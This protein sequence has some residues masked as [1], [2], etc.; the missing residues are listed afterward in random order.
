MDVVDHLILLRCG[1]ATFK[2]HLITYPILH[3]NNLSRTELI[4]SVLNISQLLV[5]LNR[6]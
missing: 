1:E 5:T 4:A 6:P 3:I 2:I